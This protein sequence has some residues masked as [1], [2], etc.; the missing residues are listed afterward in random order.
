MEK[1]LWLSI[2]I[3]VMFVVGDFIIDKIDYIFCNIGGVV[4]DVFNMM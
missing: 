3:K 4:G 1:M 2:G